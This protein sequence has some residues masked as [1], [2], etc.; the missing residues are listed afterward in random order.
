MHCGGVA[1]EMRRDLAAAQSRVLHGGCRRCCE[2]PGADSSSGHTFTAAV[3]KER[4]VRRGIN[5]AKP[6]L[7]FTFGAV[8]QGHDALLAPLS[9]N[10]NSGC[11][12]EFQVFYIESGDFGNAGSGVVHRR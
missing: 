8:P 12:T 3:W 4:T 10:P 9:H 1:E 5:T 2:K 11:G 7:Q 6:V